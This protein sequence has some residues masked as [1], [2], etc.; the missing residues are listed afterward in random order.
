MSIK[1]SNDTL[2]NRTRDLPSGCAVH[3][4]AAPIPHPQY[5]ENPDEVFKVKAIA[6]ALF[7]FLKSNWH[8]LQIISKRQLLNTNFVINAYPQSWLA[9]RQSQIRRQWQSLAEWLGLQIRN[10]LRQTL[11]ISL[12]VLLFGQHNC[13][14]SYAHFGP[15]SCKKLC[16]ILKS[17]QYVR[18]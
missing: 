6:E 14:F 15:F 8:E 7:S 12:I 5:K 11:Q 9:N 13:C 10:T 3:Q 1:I 2:A 17:N 18:G 4:P 16:T